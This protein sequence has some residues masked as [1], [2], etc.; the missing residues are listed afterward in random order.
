[1]YEQ[2]QN[3]LWN[4]CG[5]RLITFHD[6]LELEEEN[7]MLHKNLG[8]VTEEDFME[9]IIVNGLLGWLH[10]LLYDKF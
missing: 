5:M 1:M 2:F 6:L 10:H 4:L 7:M 3:R 8:N 9:L